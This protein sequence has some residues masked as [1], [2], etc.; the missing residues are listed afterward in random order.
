MNHFLEQLAGGD[1]RSIGKADDLVKQIL[2]APERFPDVI[3]GLAHDDPVVRMRCADVAEKVSKV[4]PEWLQS[5]KR[6]VL[7]H[8]ESAREKEIRWHLAQMVTRLKLTEKERQQA[9]GIM[10]E[11]W[12]DESRIVQT[13]ALQALADF[14][15]SDVALRKRLR[16][17]LEEAGRTGSA[18]VRARARI[19][20]SRMHEEEP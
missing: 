13:F 2:A 6:E 16:P 20:I 9:I 15:D 11:Y 14:G 10:F 18:A 1:R 8:A 5:H 3:A 12:E 17:L 19:L 7:T 4:H